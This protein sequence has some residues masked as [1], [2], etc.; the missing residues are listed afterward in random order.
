M[1]RS[2]LVALTLLAITH[3]TAVA[4]ACLGLASFTTGSVQAVGEASLTS[5]S[6]TVGAELGYGFPSSVF[7]GIG[8]GTRSIEA[9]NGS[10]LD[11]GASGGYQMALGKA[12]RVQLCP[13]ASFGFEIGPKNTFDSGVDRSSRRASVGLAIGGSVGSHGRLQVIPTASLSYAYGKSKAESDTG[14]TLFEI[15]DHYTLGQLGVG[16][17]LN[18]HISVRPSVDIPLGLDGGEPTF[19]LA[20]GYNFGRKHNRSEPAPEAP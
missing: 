3:T 11:L 13:V 19:R 2:L 17:V 7:G 6:R 14:A 8:I 1:R 9:Y 20:I 4:Q 15:S 5:G 12:A 10:S 18:S 16:L